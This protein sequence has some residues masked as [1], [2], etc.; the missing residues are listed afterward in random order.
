MMQTEKYKHKYKIDYEERAIYDYYA[1]NG[2]KLPRRLHN[3][4]VTSFN[5]KMSD[6][7]IRNGYEMRLPHGLGF[8]RIAMQ[9]M[10]KI[11]KDGTKILSPP[12]WKR[13]RELWYTIYPDS[14]WEEIVEIKGKPIVRFDNHHANGFVMRW[15][16]DRR[17]STFRNQKV[18]QFVA[19]KGGIKNGCYYGK[20]GLA[21]WLK[22]D[23]NFN[24]TKYY[25]KYGV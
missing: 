18:Y 4:V 12:D 17:L 22:E 11:N 3:D 1:K 23:L 15:H 6:L 25:E 24:R 16:W 8:L 5:L 21:K 19:A 2:G 20:R 14:T 13:T 7:M 9:K 10:K